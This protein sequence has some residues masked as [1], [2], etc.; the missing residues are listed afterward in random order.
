MRRMIDFRVHLTYADRIERVSVTTTD[1]ATAVRLALRTTAL[2][3]RAVFLVTARPDCG[4]GDCERAA[5]RVIKGRSAP[6]CQVCA[7]VEY[8]AAGVGEHTRQLRVNRYRAVDPAEWG[9]RTRR[10]RS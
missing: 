8:G 1:A 5:T 3:R 6:L 7:E 4:R 10:A 9:G 2:P